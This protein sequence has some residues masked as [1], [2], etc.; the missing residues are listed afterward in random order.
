M[1]LLYDAYRSLS[2]P[3]QCCDD[4]ANLATVPKNSVH[5]V[6]PYSSTVQLVASLYDQYGDYMGTGGCSGTVTQRADVILTAGHCYKVCH[7]PFQPFS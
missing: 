5:N 1:T 2:L 7:L 3:T 4:T 6:A